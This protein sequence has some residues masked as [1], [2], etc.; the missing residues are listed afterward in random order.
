MPRR[1]VS[2]SE[3]ARLAGVS[4]AAVTK[5]CRP[6][7]PLAAGCVGD[8]LD[9]DA[10]C[11]Q[12]WLSRTDGPRK[13]S[14]GARQK[15]AAKRTAPRRKRRQKQAEPAVLLDDLSAYM[16]LTLGQIIDRHGTLRALKDLLEA[17]AK[18]AAIQ[19]RELGMAES[20]TE[21]VDRNLVRLHVIG[22]FDAGHRRL[23]SD[24]A[25]TLARRLYAAA[26]SGQSLEEG[27]RVAR[28]IISAQLELAKAQAAR[29]LQDA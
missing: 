22:A 18:I 23:L 12:K 13:L 4:P 8:R 10:E 17:R 29:A 1:I 14:R 20:R 28:E 26:M 3:L 15:R 6:G 2:R 11:V 19:E 25:E 16:S 24:A 5:L 27:K 7:K 9:L 21:L